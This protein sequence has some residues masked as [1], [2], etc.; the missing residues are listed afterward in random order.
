MGTQLQLDLLA[1]VGTDLNTRRRELIQLDHRP[2]RLN[3]SS[4]FLVTSCV[5]GNRPHYGCDRYCRARSYSASMTS[6]AATTSPSSLRAP[7]GV[8]A[9][10]S[11][12]STTP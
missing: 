7:A 3:N 8:A 4:S 1:G 5:N 9:A 2:R 12:P 6:R 10:G 11:S